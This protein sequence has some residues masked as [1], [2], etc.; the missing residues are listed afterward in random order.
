MS[1]IPKSSLHKNPD[2]T[3]VFDLISTIE[4]P[5]KRIGQHPFISIIVIGVCAHIGGA[6]DSVAMAHF[7]KNHESWFRKFLPLPHG[8]PSHD[9]FNRIFGKIHKHEMQKLLALVQPAMETAEASESTENESEIIDETQDA[10]NKQIILD[11][12][13]LRA[14]KT[15][16]PTTLIRAFF[17]AKNKVLAQGKVPL[18]TNEITT[19]PKILLSVKNFIKGCICTIDAI[20]TQV[21]IAKL[22]VALGGSYFLPIKKNQPQLYED[23][24]LYMDDVAQG[25]MPG[26]KYTYYETIEKGH[27]R[28]EKRQCWTITNLNWLYRIK[29]WKDA[30]SISLVVSTVKRGKSEPVITKRYFIGERAFHAKTALAVARKHWS[31][32]NNLHW[33]LNVDF[34]EH[35]ATTRKRAGAENMAI[36]RSVALGLLENNSMNASIKNKRARAACDLDY[37]LEVL[38]GKPIDRRS[39]LQKAKDYII[40]LFRTPRRIFSCFG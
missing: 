23:V 12:K 14:L 39:T 31:I 21:K 11:G 32:E 13:V 19:I 10:V 25:T 2:M 37:M 9:T 17:P 36:V 4:D 28:I 20:G 30:K 22:I 16:N 34:R 15:L 8:I 26:A 35:T 5:R 40:T 6:N 38:L 3:R 18:G 27:G 29:R 33:P 24:S 7:G 1:S